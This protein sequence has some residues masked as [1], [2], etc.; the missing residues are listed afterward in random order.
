MT[1]KLA[2]G[3]KSS[4]RTAKPIDPFTMPFPLVLSNTDVEEIAE[5]L[6]NTVF[7]SL[8]WNKARDDP[9]LSQEMFRRIVR[10]NFDILRNRY[11]R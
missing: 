1:A 9:F 4:P 8:N 10:V 11:D 7:P 3:I 2:T 6:F 5:Q